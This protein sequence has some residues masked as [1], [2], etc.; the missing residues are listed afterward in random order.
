M[1]RYV[2]LIEEKITVDRSLG[3]A[4]QVGKG[5]KQSMHAQ[6][7]EGHQATTAL[8]KCGFSIVKSSNFLRETRNPEFYEKFLDL[9]MLAANTKQF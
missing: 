9:Y 6:P 7:G 3:I 8:W 4:D 1:L 5:M 2:T